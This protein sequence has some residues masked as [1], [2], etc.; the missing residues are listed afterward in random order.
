MSK[1]AWDFIESTSVAIAI[2]SAMGV[3]VGIFNGWTGYETAGI[4]IASG[5]FWLISAFAHKKSES[6]RKW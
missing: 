5:A 1:A 6:A 2:L 4:G 3:L